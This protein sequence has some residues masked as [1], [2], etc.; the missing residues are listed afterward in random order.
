MI[1]WADLSLDSRSCAMSMR[2]LT[3]PILAAGLLYGA[4]V[5]AQPPAEPVVDD[6]LPKGAVTRFGVTRPILRQ[7]PQVGLIP[8]KYTNFVAPTMTNGLR[9]YDLG[10]GR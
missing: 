6:P 9:R 3:M 1:R 10:T 4:L 2:A 7:S 5:F 8:P